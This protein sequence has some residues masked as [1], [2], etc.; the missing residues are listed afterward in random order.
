MH[1]RERLQARLVPVTGL[2]S[3]DLYRLGQPIKIAFGIAAVVWVTGL[4]RIKTSFSFGGDGERSDGQLLRV[5]LREGV[6][7]A[8]LACG[9]RGQIKYFFEKESRK[10]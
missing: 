2:I 4:F 8:G 10:R 7:S 9:F 3:N 6:L 1:L 5:N